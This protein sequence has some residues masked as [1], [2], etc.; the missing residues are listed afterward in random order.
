MELQ[1]ATAR[2]DAIVEMIDR[3]LHAGT[4]LL[5]LQIKSVAL[6]IEDDLGDSRLLMV[7]PHDHIIVSCDASVKVN[8]GGPAAVGVVVQFPGGE[9]NLELCQGTPATSNNQAEYD[10]IY[11]ALMTLTNL[12]NNLGKK[13]EIRSDSQLTIRQLNGEMKCQEAKLQKRR[14]LILELVEN[15]PAEVE[16]T[17]RPRNSTPELKLANYLAQDYLGVQRH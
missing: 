7:K 10:A 5:L 11:F 1:E 2:L 12:K 6:G 8:P 9:K 13:I 16:F 3:N 14:D 17:W 15:L 4:S